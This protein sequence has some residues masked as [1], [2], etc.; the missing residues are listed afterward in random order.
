MSGFSGFWPEILVGWRSGMKERNEKIYDALI[1]FCDALGLLGDSGT[2][3]LFFIFAGAFSKANVREMNALLKA[4]H[5]DR[6][7]IQY[8][9][10]HGG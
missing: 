4:G 9:A 1:A 8:A 5:K 10:A 2:E 7:G 6:D 3:D